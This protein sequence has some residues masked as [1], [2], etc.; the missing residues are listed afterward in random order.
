MDA[1][2]GDRRTLSSKK[3]IWYLFLYIYFRQKFCVPYHYYSR[4]FVASSSK[5]D[6]HPKVNSSFKSR[7]SSVRALRA[8]LTPVL[9]RPNLPT[10]DP[11]CDK[12]GIR[13]AQLLRRTHPFSSDVRCRRFASCYYSGSSH[14][15]GTYHPTGR[16]LLYGTLGRDSLA[17]PQ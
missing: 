11:Q 10:L 13:F 15:P 3:S 8:G 12:H 5:T 16:R 4:Q 17:R 1:G 14:Q 6:F 7:R 9:A 2:L